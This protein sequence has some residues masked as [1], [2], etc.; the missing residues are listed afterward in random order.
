[1]PPSIVDDIFGN[2]VG[3]A[4]FILGDIVLGYVEVPESFNYG[5]EQLQDVMQLPGGQRIV[6]VLGR[7]D[8]DITFSG[9][10]WGSTANERARALDYLRGNGDEIEFI[11]GEFVYLVV[12]K[13]YSPNFEKFY[14]VPY[15]I[16][17]TVVK[18]LTLPVPFAEGN[19]YNTAVN[20]DLQY[21][22]GLAGQTGSNELVS[23]INSL[24]SSISSAGNLGAASQDQLNS[25]IGNIQNSQ[26]INNG[27]I[28][29][30]GVN[31]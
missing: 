5:G 17:L 6:N 13:S 23:A 27:L 10:F 12:I 25:I 1:M 24:S 3:D 15:T 4:L 11:F 26:S 2:A 19:S 21:I 7:S 14:Q 30:N 16:T 28:A 29:N 9:M 31:Q 8:H 22:L 18:D 20:D